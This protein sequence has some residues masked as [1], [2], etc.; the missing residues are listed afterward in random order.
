MS[1]TVAT[2]E[3]PT[4]KR[5]FARRDRESLYDGSGGLDFVGHRKTWYSITLGLM[6]VAILAMFI[7]GFNMGIDL[8]LIHI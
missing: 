1:S 4:T 6:V 2:T 5:G 3:T 8:S 7:R